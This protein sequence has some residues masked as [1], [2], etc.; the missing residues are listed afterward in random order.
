MSHVV[1]IMVTEKLHFYHVI[2]YH[3]SMDGWRMLG[4][5]GDFS[6]IFLDNLPYLKLW[7]CIVSTR[8][9]NLSDVPALLRGIRN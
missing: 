6:D 1:V 4:H 9:V 5:E 3:D 7:K 8:N 2:L